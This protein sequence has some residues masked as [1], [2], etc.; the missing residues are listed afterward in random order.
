MMKSVILS[1]CFTAAAASA[2]SLTGNWL[3]AIPNGDGTVQRTYLNLKQQ[4]GRITGTIRWTLHLFTIDRSSGGPGGFTISG[5]MPI[6]GT[7][8]RKTYRGKLAGNEL[9]LK[10]ILATGPGPTLIARRVPAGEGALPPRIPPPPLRPVRWNGLARTPPM[11]WNSW[12]KFANRVDDATVRQIA[13]AMARNGMREDGY[14]YVTIDD[15]W[16]GERDAR[17]EIHPNRKFPDMKA[18]ADYVHSRG[19]K[20]GIYSSPGPVTCEGYEGSYGHEQQDANT[21]AAWGI[22]FLKYDWCG[23]FMIYKDSEMQAVY[24][25]MGEALLASGRPIVYS[26]CQYGVGE[27]WKWGADAGGNLWRT[28]GDIRD[29]WESMSRIGFSQYPLAPFAR[30]GHW[31]DPD[32]LEIGNGGMTDTEYRTHMSL[33]SM[34]A[35]PLIAG[36]DVRNMTPSIREIVLNREVIAIDQDPAGRQGKRAW[37]SGMREVWTRELA[38]GDTALAVFNRAPQDARVTFRWADAGLVNPP[39]RIRDVWRHTDGKAAGPE[40]SADVPGHGV[41]M[42][43]VR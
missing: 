10:E 20:L 33:W 4:D 25:K 23:A 2:A 42:L 18:L 22:D 8:R 17:G 16:A 3:I 37:Q 12:N 7:E 24:Q 29:T 26:I 39:S 43:R 40:Y 21:Y 14:V 1:V 15:T 31:N 19:L 36:N 27:V 34:L 41:V 6:L 32:M 13:D 5:G 9:Q 38:G 28:G 30:P 35:A 11:G